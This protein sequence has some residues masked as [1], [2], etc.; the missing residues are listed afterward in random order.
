MTNRID[1]NAPRRRPLHAADVAV[2]D[3]HARRTSPEEIGFQI[4]GALAFLALGALAGAMIA[5]SWPQ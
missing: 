5:A 1:P 3:P 4:A 2:A